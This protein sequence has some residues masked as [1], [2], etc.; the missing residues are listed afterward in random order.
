MIYTGVEK[1]QKFSKS[2]ENFY[3]NKKNFLNN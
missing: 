1:S 2:S 3:E